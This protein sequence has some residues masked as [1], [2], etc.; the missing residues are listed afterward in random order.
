MRSSLKRKL[1]LYCLTVVLMAMVFLVIAGVSELLLRWLYVSSAIEKLDHVEETA[2]TPIRFKGGYRGSLWGIPFHT[3]RFGFRDEEEFS[4][5]PPPGEYRIL[6]LGD[7]IGFGLGIP[8]ADHYT[9]VLE[10][11]LN[12]SKPGRTFR[13]I[14]AG[15][16]GYCPSGYFA[17]LNNEGLELKPDLVIIETE[18][19]NDTTDEAL[20]EWGDLDDRGYLEEIKGGRYVVSWDGRQ[21]GTYATGNCFL[22]KTYLYTDLVRRILNLSRRISPKEPWNTRPGARVYYSLGFDQFLLDPQRLEKGDRQ[23][24]AALSGTVDLLRSNG[25]DCLIMIM[26]SRYLY[27][28]AYD[29]T[30]MA[31]SIYRDALD[32]A[33]KHDL[34]FMDMYDTI[35]KNGGE[36][37]FLDFAHLTS[38]GNRAVGL[39]LYNRISGLMQDEQPD[40]EGA[41]EE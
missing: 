9:K 7:S 25:I 28:E 16:Q 19:C 29:Y 8:S 20:V 12:G 35:E 11:K 6:S 18:L 41:R 34:P 15:G 13:V 5:E 22:E 37:L 24:F 38:E 10:R 36:E 26:P 39:E 3:N 30:A 1:K 21:L 40:P 33:A 32:S 14:N 31:S 17:Y 4:T 27:Q 23:L 2:Y